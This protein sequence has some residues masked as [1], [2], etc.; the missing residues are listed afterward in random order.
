MRLGLT[1]YSADLKRT[2]DHDSPENR[3]QQD[4]KQSNPT[5]DYDDL[6]DNETSFLVEWL[7]WRFCRTISF[8]W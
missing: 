5:R 1:C 7:R 4:E 2:L 6:G 3:E 8:Q